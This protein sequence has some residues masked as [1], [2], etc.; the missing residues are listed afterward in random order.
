MNC[1]LSRPFRRVVLGTFLFASAQSY[2]ELRDI[3]EEG[4]SDVWGQ[5]MFELTNSTI[6][7]SPALGVTAPIGDTGEV[8]GPISFSKITVGAEIEL[9]AEIGKLRL[10]SYARGVDDGGADINANNIIFTGYQ[11]DGVYYPFKAKNPYFEFAMTN[12]TDSGTREILGFRFGF[13]QVDGMLGAELARLSGRVSLTSKNVPADPANPS[14]DQKQLLIN[15]NGVRDAGSAQVVTVTGGVPGVPGAAVSNVYKDVEAVCLGRTG[16]QGVCGAGTD[17]ATKDFWISVN[18]V[19]NLFYP[20]A[21]AD[22]SDYTPAQKGVWMNL[23]D[24]ARVYY[25]RNTA[26]ASLDAF[27]NPSPSTLNIRRW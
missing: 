11:R 18:K 9:D 5:A 16:D 2:A 23:T 10:G 25:L 20:K 26:D 1:Y 8:A 21:S 15:G 13:E 12:P 19:N 24:N 27:K 4:M 14:G 7:P 6:T 3:G 17:T 22:V